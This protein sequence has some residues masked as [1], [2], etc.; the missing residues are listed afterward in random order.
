LSFD[1]VK[2]KRNICVPGLPFESVIGF[3]FKA[4]LYAM[5][6][7]HDYGEIRR[8]AIRVLHDRLHVLC[9]VDLDDGIRVI[10]VRRLMPARQDAMAKRRPMIGAHAEVRGLNSRYLKRLRSPQESR[11]D[12]PRRKIGIRSPGKAPT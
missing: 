4:A 12:A 9:F 11:P 3:A 5:D 8:V 1:A 10:S 2:N 7:R 6:G